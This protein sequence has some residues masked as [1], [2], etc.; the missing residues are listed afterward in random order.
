MASVA[1]LVVGGVLVV[2]VMVIMRFVGWLC[3][4]FNLSEEEGVVE[5]WVFV[6]LGGVAEAFAEFVESQRQILAD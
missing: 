3:L 1:D 6:Y 5:A 4:F 2:L